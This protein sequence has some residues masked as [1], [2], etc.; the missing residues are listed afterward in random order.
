MELFVAEEFEECLQQ[1][2]KIDT[3]NKIV[4]LIKLKSYF[5]LGKY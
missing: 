5:L 2:N 1:I 3:N 4:F